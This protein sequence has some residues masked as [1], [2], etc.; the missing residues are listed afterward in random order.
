M[1]RLASTRLTLDSSD[2]SW[3]VRRHER[4]LAK[5]KAGKPAR[6]STDRPI[7][8]PQTPEPRHEHFADE[9]PKRSKTRASPEHIP[10]YSDEPVPRDAQAF[11]DHILA[12][13][14]SSGRVHQEP[15]AR[16]PRVIVPSDTFL[17]NHASVHL[18]IRGE[19]G[20]EQD[21]ARNNGPLQELLISPR[22][23]VSD[24]SEPSTEIRSRLSPLSLPSLDGDENHHQSQSRQS[25]SEQLDAYSSTK[26]HI[27]TEHGPDSHPF[28]SRQESESQWINQMDGDGP[29]DAAPSL[30]HHRSPSSLQDP[31][32]GSVGMPFGAQ[33]RRAEL[34][35]SRNM[36]GSDPT[37]PRRTHSWGLQRSRLYI[38]EVAASSS[39]DKHP[40][41][42]GQLNDQV[43]HNEAGLLS[44]PPRRRK[45]YKR[46]SETYSLVASEAST[47]HAESM[48]AIFASNN[49]FNPTG[50]RNSPT[51]PVDL[52]S[53]PGSVQHHQPTSSPYQ[54]SS[55][56]HPSHSS[57][58]YPNG[59]S[60]H[61]RNSS[62][63][64]LPYM[65]NASIHETPNPLRRPFERLPIPFSASSRIQ[66][67]NAALPPN[68]PTADENDCYPSSPYIPRTP[69]RSISS[70]SMTAT[71]T[72]ISI[73]D[74]SLPAY[75]QPQTPIGLPRNGLPRMSLQNPFFTAPARAGTRSGRGVTGWLY[76]AFATPSRVERRREVGV[77]RGRDEQENVSVEVEAERMERRERDG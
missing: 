40:K 45:G 61:S 35:A 21:Q 32:P 53:S 55:M 19:N 72:R 26:Q 6:V 17:E 71:P 9:L 4:R 34:A 60:F 18:S 65:P 12:E 25:S 69:P 2:V 76:S 77:W 28:M 52:V 20:D 11:W 1:L 73:Y 74:D 47:T 33:A 16:S 44:L 51:E 50:D 10:I 7:A 14:A 41:T 67:T 29:S 24:I 39:P 22:S 68:T 57:P 23:P 49:P 54:R 5:L 63:I 56:S 70:T 58:T 3:H 31:E 62:S 66:S 36:S 38:S 48:Q 30:H 59:M 13:A 43:P 8:K 37:Q 46:R 75:F 42:P 15:L 27:E 64:E